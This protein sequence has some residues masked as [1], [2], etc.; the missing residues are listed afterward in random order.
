MSYNEL[1]TNIND[2]KRKQLLKE[3]S[4]KSKST[5][6]QPYVE[7]SKLPKYGDPDSKKFRLKIISLSITPTDE[8]GNIINFSSVN[9]LGS[10]IY[11]NYFSTCTGCSNSSGFGPSRSG[12]VTTPP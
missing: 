4:S 8:K 5:K 9:S 12:G 11:D 6:N 2:I 3:E 1:Q 10:N 7:H